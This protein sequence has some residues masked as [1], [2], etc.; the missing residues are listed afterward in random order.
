M[1]KRAD[2]YTM[3]VVNPSGR[4]LPGDELDGLVTYRPM[5]DGKRVSYRIPAEVARQLRDEPDPVKRHA[6]AK[7]AALVG[8]RPRAREAQVDVATGGRVPKPDD[9]TSASGRFFA[10]VEGREVEVDP[11]DLVGSPTRQGHRVDLGGPTDYLAKARAR[12]GRSPRAEPGLR[13]PPRLQ[14]LPATFKSAKAAA[15]Q[16][17]AGN[18]DFFDGVRDPWDGLREWMDGVETKVGKRTRR[19]HQTRSG[20]A[21]LGE[22]HAEHAIRRALAYVFGKAKGRRW[23]SVHWG[24]VERLGEALAPYFEPIA[25]R[26]GRA[27]IYWTP[28]LEGVGSE[29]FDALSDRDR[30]KLTGCD[31]QTA[32]REAIAAL[33]TAFSG[34]RSCLPA[35]H[36]RIVQ[37]RLQE[38]TRW[39]NDPRKIPAYACEPDPI[40]GGM[41]CDYPSVVLELRALERACEGN[42]YDPAWAAD[43]GRSGTPGFVRLNPEAPLRVHYSYDAGIL[44]CGNTRPY[45]DAIKGLGTKRFRFSRNLDDDCTWYV[46]RSRH[47]YVAQST[48]DALAKELRAATSVEVAVDYHAPDPSE[49]SF[50]AQE[51]GRLERSQARADRLETRADMRRKESDAAYE[52]SRALVRWAPGQPVL[53]DHHSAKRHLRDLERVDKKMRA[54]VEASGEAKRLAS[55]AKR[56]RGGVESRQSAG[57]AHRRIAERQRELRKLDVELTGQAP[58]GWRGAHPGG[59]ATGA[60]REQLRVRRAEIISELGHWETRLNEL[61]AKA[62]GPEDFGPGDILSDGSVVVRVNAKSLTVDRPKIDMWGLKHPYADVHGKLERSSDRWRFTI[63]LYA[64]WVQGRSPRPRGFDKRIK[65]ANRWLAECA[66]SQ[67]PKSIDDEPSSTAVRRVVKALRPGEVEGLRRIGRGARLHGRTIPEALVGHGLLIGFA[68]AQRKLTPLGQAVLAALP[69]PPTPRAGSATEPP[70]ALRRLAAEASRK[71]VATALRRLLRHHFPS[72]AVSLTTP[73]HSMAQT[74]DLRP[75]SGKRWSAA[76]RASLRAV[77]GDSVSFAGDDALLWPDQKASEGGTVLTAAYVEDFTSWLRDPNFQPTTRPKATATA[78]GRAKSSTKRSASSSSKT[79]TAKAAAPTPV[80]KKRKARRRSPNASLPKKVSDCGGVLADW[81]RGIAPLEHMFAGGGDPMDPEPN[82]AAEKTMAKKTASKKNSKTGSKSR[83]KKAA[84]KKSARRSASR[85]TSAAEAPKKKVAKKK[86]KKKAAKK[87]SSAAKKKA[88]AGQEV[89]SATRKAAAKGKR[90]STGRPKS[91]PA[92]SSRPSPQLKQTRERLD[93][94]TRMLSVARSADGKAKTEAAM[95]ASGWGAVSEAESTR[96]LEGTLAPSVRRTLESMLRQA[97]SVQR[98]AQRLA[99]LKKNPGRR[100][101]RKSAPK[102]AKSSAV[103]DAVVLAAS[104]RVRRALRRL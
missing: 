43:L 97:R 33:E 75:R 42:G 90:A 13:C 32:L 45:K 31:A 83:P 6:K 18:E 52:A 51:E 53:V 56:S 82:P 102:P 66:A 104:D 103:A 72:L 61:A 88:T 62:W 4:P 49:V 10:K 11:D 29:A 98:D 47:K 69:P 94:A 27:A 54:S 17:Y 39:A 50:E 59:P 76:E 79:P 78:R 12:R 91:R 89:P 100:S 38:W 7:A 48:I 3:L 9:G 30:A 36:R 55:A 19:L 44:I 68:P 2:S 95:E 80:D 63:Q 8:R 22:A 46:Q 58:P 84:S 87:R 37:R 64:T 57:F 41:T 26:G 28:I 73:R 92:T 16:F 93:L 96:Q 99:G 60:Y 77:F 35:K 24:S 65:L 1:V 86:T 25:G 81:R 21:I 5:V 14:G 15:E 67:S 70:G 74:L 20:T 40:T 71:E 34:Q 23:D 101:K 85:S